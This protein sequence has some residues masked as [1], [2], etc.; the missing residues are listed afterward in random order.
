MVFVTY[1][2]V[3]WAACLTVC[4]GNRFLPHLN[5]LGLVF[6]IA[7]LLIT[8]I[9]V[10][11]MPSRSGQPGHAPS[12]FVWKDW[13]A[14]IGYPDGFVFLIGMLNGAF[15]VGTPDCVSHLAEEVGSPG[16]NIPKAIGMWPK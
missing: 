14:D 10:A 12:D 3:S 8:V 9:V 6:I 4:F 16:I 1:I 2:I 11:V 15:S 7:G 13:Q 5:T